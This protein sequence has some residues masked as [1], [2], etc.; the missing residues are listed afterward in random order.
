MYS[1]PNL[2]GTNL[3]GAKGCLSAKFNKADLRGTNVSYTGLDKVELE[4]VGAKVD[5]NT[6][7]L[8]VYVLKSIA[9]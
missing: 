6:K 8:K 7:G 9:A 1:R 2:R 4:S 5:G 3:S